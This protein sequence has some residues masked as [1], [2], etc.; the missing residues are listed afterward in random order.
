MI[1]DEQF[2][3]EYFAV[4]SP[5]VKHDYRRIMAIIDGF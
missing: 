4:E 3:D 5:S 1:T 2:T